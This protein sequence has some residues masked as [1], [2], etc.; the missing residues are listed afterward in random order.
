MNILKRVCRILAILTAAA[1]LLCAVLVSVLISLNAA[2]KTAAHGTQSIEI[3]DEGS[4]LFEVKDG[5]SS[6]SV[7]RRLAEAGVIHN[8]LLWNIL[9]RLD[10][11][12][13]KTGVYQIELPVNQIALHKILQEGRQKLLRVTVAEGLT[14]KKTAAIVENAGICKAEDFIAACADPAVL[15]EFKI[16]AANAE[17]FLYPDTY[18]FTAHYP[19]NLVVKKMIGTFF[20]RLTEIGVDYERL[21]PV[22]LY[23]KVILASIVEREYRDKEEAPV[24]AG[25][26]Q[27]R[28][29]KRMRLE[30]CATVEYIIT[31][32]EGKPHPAR[33]FNQDTQ[34]NHPYN[35][36]VRA[37]L[38]PGPIAS[39][40][41]VALGAAFFPASSEYLFFRVI[42]P[43]AGRH[44]F[45]KTFDDHIK[46]GELYLKRFR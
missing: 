14:L 15:N 41:A 42:D 11:K 38:P 33:L 39:P 30:S 25:V 36:Y 3:T 21:N 35:T 46:A 5:E 13:I 43:D 26:F 18:L 28:L 40:G 10:R 6:I 16:H 31:E 45:S 17:G 1:V 27:N 22:E 34:K 20:Q 23:N 9:S 29:N 4:A 24:I 8:E 7:G 2:P 12:F 32:I 19:A 44:Y 37:G